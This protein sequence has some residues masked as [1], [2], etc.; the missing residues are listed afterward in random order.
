MSHYHPTTFAERDRFVQLQQQG[1]TYQQIADECGWK[2]ET[3]RKHCRTF[4]RAG[5]VTLSPQRVGRKRRGC[6]SI[7]A[8]VVR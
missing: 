7:F 6:L 2:R 1:L 4:R 8:P 5:A 3:V